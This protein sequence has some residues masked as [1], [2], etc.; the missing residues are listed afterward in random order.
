MSLLPSHAGRLPLAASGRL[1]DSVTTNGSYGSI[2][3]QALTNSYATS[4][5][6]PK[7][8]AGKAKA[9]TKATKKRSASSASTKKASKAKK[10]KKTEAKK[11]KRKAL[12]EEQKEARK[13]K[14]LKQKIKELKAMALE[15]PKRLSGTAHSLA[16]TDMLA[17]LKG[18]DEGKSPQEL[19][20]EA[21]AAVKALSPDELEVC[22]PAATLYLKS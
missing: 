16:V 18:K 13:A 1:V 22:S 8:N 12:T 21:T 20:K 11:P 3:S 9:T 19:F 5:G 17:K 10:P 2:L 4:A 6:R 15:P 7:A 14:E